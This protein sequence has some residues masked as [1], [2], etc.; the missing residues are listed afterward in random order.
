MANE[1]HLSAVKKGVEAWNKWRE[2]NPK[3]Q[4]D[5]SVADL[6][7][8]NLSWVDLSTADVAWA[9]LSDANLSDA[10]LAEANLS[11]ANF[12]RANLR[13]SKFIKA[14]LNGAFFHIPNASGFEV[15]KR[16]RENAKT[17]KIQILMF[18]SVPS[19]ENVKTTVEIGVDGFLA[20]PFDPQSMG[21]KVRQMIQKG[22]D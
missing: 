10:R 14:N 13:R 16:L 1:D 4:P 2:S 11:R 18:T 8:A 7:G 22:R 20:K 12:N 5:L 9:S 15:C 17:E 3:V 19:Q 6:S 21:Q